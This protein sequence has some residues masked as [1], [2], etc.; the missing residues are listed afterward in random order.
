MTM[1]IEGCIEQDVID[2]QMALEAE[3]KQKIALAA[4][5]G[6]IPTNTKEIEFNIDCT[7]GIA[8]SIEY[9]SS[10]DRL[11]HERSDVIIPSSLSEWFVFKASV[12]RH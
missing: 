9:W 11:D 4:A 6:L 2:F 12:W 5:L 10:T 3:I 8:K 7:D 1:D